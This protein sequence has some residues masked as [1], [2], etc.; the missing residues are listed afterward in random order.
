MV[1]SFPEAGGAHNCRELLE[2]SATMD[3]AMFETY[4]KEVC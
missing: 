3:K 1:A 4:R 2:Q